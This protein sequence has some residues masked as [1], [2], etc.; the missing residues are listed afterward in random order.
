MLG[1][2]RVARIAI[3][4][5]T[6]RISMRVKPDRP[7]RGIRG[8]RGTTRKRQKR[9]LRVTPRIP[10]IPRLLLSCS[11]GTP[12]LEDDMS[13]WK[14]GKGWKIGHPMGRNSFRDTTYAAITQLRKS[15]RAGGGLC[16]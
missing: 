6:T 7:S 8:A 2:T 4:T 3:T 16:L 9:S 15:L 14:A 1:A 13:L 11:V 12:V 10:R 5:I